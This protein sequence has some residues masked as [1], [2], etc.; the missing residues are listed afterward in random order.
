MTEPV[1]HSKEYKTI[2]DN[3]ES[4]ELAIMGKDPYPQDLIGI[5]FCKETWS[6][7]RRDNCSGYYVLKSLGINFDKVEAYFDF[8]KDLF[9]TGDGCLLGLGQEDKDNG[10]IFIRDITHCEAPK[11]SGLVLHFAQQ[12]NAPDIP[13]II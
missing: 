10:Q 3:T 1:L 13:M 9:I 12:I 4:F 2:I 11:Q 6:D 8:P 7:L 5:P